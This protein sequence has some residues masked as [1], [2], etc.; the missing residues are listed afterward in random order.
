MRNSIILILVF[1]A[2]LYLS[3]LKLSADHKYKNPKDNY[4]SFS[5]LTRFGLGYKHHL[6]R[7]FAWVCLSAFSR[8]K[9][10]SIWRIVLC[11]KGKS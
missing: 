9:H 10:T 11:L 6:G 4:L 7:N 1:G 5:A 2:I 3:P 8:R